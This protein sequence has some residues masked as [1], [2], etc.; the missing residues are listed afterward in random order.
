MNLIQANDINNNNRLALIG[1]ANLASD[2]YNENRRQYE[3]YDKNEQGNYFIVY[4]IPDFTGWADKHL[5]IKLE[6]LL[7][8]EFEEYEI[9]YDPF[10]GKYEHWYANRRRCALSFHTLVYFKLGEK[11]EEPLR[12]ILKETF[13]KSYGFDDYGEKIFEE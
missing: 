3:A 4:A 2:Y 10:G 13:R 6:I 1:K 11:F 5:R 12:E 7:E 8:D 9:E